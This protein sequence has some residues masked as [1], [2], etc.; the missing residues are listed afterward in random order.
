MVDQHHRQQVAV[1][2]SGLQGSIPSLPPQL[3]HLASAVGTVQHPLQPLR[4]DLP[5]GFQM[6]SEERIE[7]KQLRERLTLLLDP[8]AALDGIPGDEAKAALITKVVRGLAGAANPSEAVVTAKTSLY[9]DGVGEL[10]AWAIDLA[11]KRWAKGSC[12]P[13]IE[14]DPDFNWPPCPATLSK[15]AKLELQPL[16]RDVMALDNLLAAVPTS[17]AMDPKPL[18]PT[19]DVPRL[20][21]RGM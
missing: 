20:G 8:M 19:S 17:R 15:L 11:I 9:A 5:E 14:K 1:H 21:M 2:A 12:P 3:R 6:T 16:Q 4:Y 18:S 13:E 7:A 10:P